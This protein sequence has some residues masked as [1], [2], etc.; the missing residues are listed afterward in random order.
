MVTEQGK[1]LDGEAI[2]FEQT[3]ETRHY[4]LS[5]KYQKFSKGRHYSLVDKIQ[6]FLVPDIDSS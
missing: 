3:C 1:W 6:S 4:Y 2:F 5:A